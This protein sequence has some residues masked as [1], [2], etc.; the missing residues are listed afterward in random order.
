MYLNATNSAGG[1]VGG[2]LTLTRVVFE[3]GDVYPHDY[4]VINLTLTRVVFEYNL[5]LYTFRKYTI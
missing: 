1:V 5:L 4:V 3:S 2:D